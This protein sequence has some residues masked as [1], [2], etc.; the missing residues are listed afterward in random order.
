MEGIKATS[1]IGRQAAERRELQV[2]SIGA[3]GD[4]LLATAD[5]IDSAAN[6]AGGLGCE[7][8]E[9]LRMIAAMARCLAG[10]LARVAD[11]EAA[12]LLLKGAP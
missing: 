3:M 8:C 9:R 10:M 1:G 7:Q 11:E 2:D 5:V 12:R 6:D 4:L